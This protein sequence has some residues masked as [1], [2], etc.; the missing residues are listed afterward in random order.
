MEIRPNDTVKMTVEEL[1]MLVNTC[2]MKDR[3]EQP[4]QVNYEGYVKRFLVWPN[5]ETDEKEMA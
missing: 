4:E 5:S 3:R 2:V 1:V